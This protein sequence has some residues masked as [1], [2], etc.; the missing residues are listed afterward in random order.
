MNKIS[1]LF[2]IVGAASCTHADLYPGM[3]VHCIRD[4]DCPTPSEA[5]E[6]S[7][8]VCGE[9]DGDTSLVVAGCT[10]VSTRLGDICNEG[11]GSCVITNPKDVST[12]TCNQPVTPKGMTCSVPIMPSMDDCITDSECDD[13]SDCTIDKC[14]LASEASSQHGWCLHTEA[15]TTSNTC[16]VT[17]GSKAATGLCMSGG[18]CCAGT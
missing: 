4:G 3:P 8:Y 11:V 16:K 5:A 18:A 1:A 10:A 15:H 12:A 14:I 2:F 7:H 17:F 13:G 9:D 6:C